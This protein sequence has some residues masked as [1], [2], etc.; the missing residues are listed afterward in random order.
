MFIYYL[1]LFQNLLIILSDLKKDCYYQS[2]EDK[3]CEEFDHSQNFKN[4][5]EREGSW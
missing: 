1:L 3:T 5:L 4:L 2:I